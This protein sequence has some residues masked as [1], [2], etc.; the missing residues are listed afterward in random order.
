MRI[1]AFVEER[2]ER[3][4]RDCSEYGGVK[5]EEHSRGRRPPAEKHPLNQK[6]CRVRREQRRSNPNGS[7]P[8]KE[9]S[10]KLC[11]DDREGGCAGHEVGKAFNRE[12][13]Q[14]QS[15]ANRV[16]SYL[17]CDK[18]RCGQRRDHLG[19]WSGHGT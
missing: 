12:E 5:E 3:R 4:D 1:E 2:P 15:I 13:G 16:R 18:C 17:L 9:A 14:E 11:R 6:E 7:K 19:L 10:G 8:R